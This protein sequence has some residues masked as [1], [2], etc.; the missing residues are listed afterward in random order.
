MYMLHGNVFVCLCSGNQHI[1]SAGGTEGGRISA[2]AE[3]PREVHG[4][5][6]WRGWWGEQR[7]R[8]DYFRTINSSL[9]RPIWICAENVPETREQTCL[10]ALQ[11]SHTFAAHS[12]SEFWSVF[13][14]WTKERKETEM[15]SHTYNKWYDEWQLA[16][17]KVGCNAE[18][19][20][21]VFDTAR[22]WGSS[23]TWPGLRTVL[24]L[25]SDEE[26][27]LSA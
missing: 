21:L 24:C 17:G 13:D 25:W 4:L 3:H 19:H 14:C 23:F 18:I 15:V 20:C 1:Q 2:E 10:H 26:N 11:R 12:L 16:R 22:V 9:A 7:R 27:G 5:L 8:T 6:V